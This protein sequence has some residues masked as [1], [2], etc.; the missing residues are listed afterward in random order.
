MRFTHR[1]TLLSLFVLAAPCFVFSVS[2]GLVRTGTSVAQEPPEPDSSEEVTAETADDTSPKDEQEPVELDVI[3]IRPSELGDE[4]LLP[5]ED[6]EQDLGE[7]A[8]DFA[9]REDADDAE[10][11]EGAEDA[12]NS[13]DAEISETPETSEA[14]E[15]LRE[16]DDSDEPL[17]P[18]PID[19][20]VNSPELTPELVALRDTVRS[21]LSYHL[22]RP[23]AVERRS[24]WGI[25]HALI[26][27]GVDT[28]VTS[29]GRPVNAI[30]W[31]CWNYPCRGQRLMYIRNG[32]LQ[33]RQGPGVQ[34]HEGQF[35]AMLAQ[36]K[37]MLDYPLQV[38]G[39]SL[40][41]A[42][43]V[44]HEQ[45]TC[46]ERT[47]LTFK[48]IGLSHYLDLDTTW[49]N[50]Q[51]QTWS[52]PKLIQ[53][54]LAQPINGAACGGTH[55]LMGF[56][57]AVHRREKTGGTMDG[58]WL[59]AK[60][61]L[62]S[63]HEYTFQLQNRDGSF[64]TNWF[65]GPGTMGTMDRRIETTGH[66]LEWMV[67]SLSDEQLRDPRVIRAVAFLADLMASHPDHD[68]KI[69]PRGHALHALAMY[70]ERVFGGRPGHRRV[71]L[72]NWPP[73]EKRK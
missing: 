31:L 61:Y 47:E 35:L 25:M 48:L 39:H 27:Y 5:I 45:V 72:A 9:A 23:E 38:D 6:V 43:L 68:W 44:K 24:P 51:G 26:A 73:A 30:G 42:D 65:R 10:K 12:Q 54:E 63:Y 16:L 40:T 21:V 50:Q 62:E 32:Q 22:M 69:G 28:E 8:G 33:T 46:R 17:L 49:R 55:R 4:T 2:L 15:A 14:P 64:S 18:L 57:F 3:P 20:A 53:E 56:S 34:G 7:A 29:G 67:F 59:R 66:I 19:D 52:I 36:S 13:K 58:Q 1:W 71:E 70:D 37:V 41:V 11:A 60:K